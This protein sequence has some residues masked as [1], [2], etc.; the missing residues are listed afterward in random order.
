M[1]VMCQYAIL[2]VFRVISIG[3]KSIHKEMYNING[4]KKSFLF[5]SLSSEGHNFLNQEF[6]RNTDKC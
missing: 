2:T 3:D 4:A 6:I 5:I 1:I